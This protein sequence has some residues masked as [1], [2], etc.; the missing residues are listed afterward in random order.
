MRWVLIITLLVCLPLAGVLLNGQSITLFLEFPPV[1][2]HELPAPFNGW[3]FGIITALN[4][5]MLA[6]LFYLFK[7]AYDKTVRAAL[8]VK[9][10]FPLWGWIGA[11]ILLTGWFLAWTRLSWFAPLQRHTFCLPWVGYVLL[12]NA[13]CKKRS[14]T[15]LLVESPARFLLLLPVSAIFWWYFEF[16]NRLVQNWYYIGVENFGPGA[17]FIFASLPFATVLPAVLSTQRLLLTLPLFDP[18]L[19]GHSHLNL[20]DTKPVA[21]LLL[22]V[23]AVCLILIGRFPYHL[24][25]L[26]WGAPLLVITAMQSFW[27]ETTIFTPLTRGDWRAFVA[28]AVAALICGFFWELWN[29]Y[30]L[31]R[32]AY[33]VPFV[34]RFH[35]FAMPALGYGGYLPFG[36]ECLLLGRMVMGDPQLGISPTSPK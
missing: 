19:A 23:G 32:W 26:V 21:I 10:R 17:Y 31:A 13:W 35:L 1:P 14:G 20:P 8:V 3:V 9:H 30:S 16:L 28:A 22:L 15:C 24:Y 29:L 34:D 12:A 4:I 6:G 36:L 27:R 33:T 11:G 5:L 25:P 18:G 7:C 2:R